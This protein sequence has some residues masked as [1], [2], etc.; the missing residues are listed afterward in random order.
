MDYVDFVVHIFTARAREFY[1]LERLWRPGSAAEYMNWIDSALKSYPFVYSPVL[2][3]LAVYRT[4][5]KVLE[6][7][8]TVL[9]EGE[10]AQAK[11]RSLSGSH[12]NSTRKHG[13]FI[14]I[15]LSSASR[16]TRRIRVIRLRTRGIHGAINSKLGKFDLAQSGS[17]VL[18]EIANV[19]MRVQAKLLNVVEVKQLFRLGGRGRSMSIAG[20][21]RCPAYLWPGRERKTFRQDLFFR[22]NRLPSGSPLRE[23]RQEVASRSRSRCSPACAKIQHQGGTRPLV[24]TVLGQYE[25]PGNIR[26]LR[27]GLNARCDQHSRVDYPGV[28]ARMVSQRVSGD[29]KCCRLK[30]SNGT[31]SRKYSRRHEERRYGRP[32]YLVSAARR[33]WKSERNTVCHSTW[34]CYEDRNM[35]SPPVQTAT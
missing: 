22:L 31:T 6:G 19:E 17:V 34:R 11:T 33:C 7:D 5:E 29:G 23:R 12:Y 14:K 24:R 13:P 20:S 16:G 10:S 3:L 21:L 35:R 27:N 1:D 4:L 9:I 25:F 2:P 18:D 30:I 32:G 15:D 8:T 28:L 26:G